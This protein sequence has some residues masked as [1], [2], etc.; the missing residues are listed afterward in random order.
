MDVYVCGVGLTKIS[1]H[2]AKPLRVLMAEA[3][4]KALEDA[5]NPEPDLIV[6]S[7]ALSPLLQKQSHLGPVVLEEL[8]LT[9]K[10]VLSV[11]SGG[12]SGAVAFHAGYMAVR[13]GLY[14]TVLVIGGEKLSD[15]LPMDVVSA[16]QNFEEREHV[17]FYGI[18]GVSLSALAYKMYLKKN[19]VKREEVASLAVHDHEMAVGVKHAQYPF[20]IKLEAVLRAT[21]ISEPITLFESFGYGDGAAAVVLTS[22]R[23]GDG[24][25]R[26]AGCAISTDRVTPASKIGSLSFPSTVKAAENAYRMAGIG[27]GDVDVAEIYDPYTIIGV[28]SLEDLGFAERGKGAKLV[29]EGE[30]K[31]GGKIPV[32]TFG[33]LKARGNPLG[34]TGLYQIAEI[35]IQLRGEAPHQVDSPKYGLA[36]AMGGFGGSSVVTILGR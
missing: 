17:S 11:E 33:G 3:A 2:W 25:V 6:V 20:P 21:T 28:I 10:P 26:V 13:S 31:P 16:M 35:A 30:V 12:A 5:G 7:S 22:R 23:N 9:G 1:E 27:P 18:T 14:S 4:L 15:A 32:N 8:G 19:G 24:C 34:A 29:W 36:H